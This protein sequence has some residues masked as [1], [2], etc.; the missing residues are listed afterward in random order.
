MPTQKTFGDPALFRAL[1]HDGEKALAQIDA[2]YRAALVAYCY[3]IV[4]DEHLAKEVVL[5]VLQK[6]WE[7]RR[8]VSAMQSPVA[9]LF[10]CVANKALNALKA[11]RKFK[12][13]PVDNAAELAVDAGIEKD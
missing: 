10:K 7:E 8:A 3:D 6:L 9:W 5:D 1:S 4:A 13:V 11:K 12:V 2:V